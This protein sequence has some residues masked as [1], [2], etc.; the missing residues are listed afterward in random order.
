MKLMNE[1]DFAKLF[2]FPMAI[3]NEFV[4]VNSVTIKRDSVFMAG[5]EKCEEQAC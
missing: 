3:P 5:N 4:R 2:P 1:P